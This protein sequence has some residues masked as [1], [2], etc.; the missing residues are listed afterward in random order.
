M[1][2]YGHCPRCGGNRA[3][4][5]SYRYDQDDGHD[6]WLCLLC[7]NIFRGRKHE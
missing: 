1:R 6:N 2:D 3:V 5:M 7:D 4:A